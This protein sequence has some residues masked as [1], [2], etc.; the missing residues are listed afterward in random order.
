MSRHLPMIRSDPSLVAVNVCA[1]FTGSYFGWH[2][3][4]MNGVPFSVPTPDTSRHRLLMPVTIAGTGVGR[5]GDVPDPVRHGVD[6]GLDGAAPGLGLGVA[7]A[8]PGP[9]VDRDQLDPVSDLAERRTARVALADRRAALTRDVQPGRPDRVHRE[10]SGVQQV[11]DPLRARPPVAGDPQHVARGRRRRAEPHR[12]DVRDRVH[13]PCQHQVPVRPPDQLG[14]P[15]HATRRAGQIRAADGRGRGLLRYSPSARS[16]P[17]PRP[18]KQL[19]AVATHCRSTSAPVQRR[20]MSSIF[21]TNVYALAVAGVPP[22]MACAGTPPNVV[23]ASRPTAPAT[24]RRTAFIVPR[25]T[26]T[27]GTDARVDARRRCSDAG[28]A[29]GYGA[30]TPFGLPLLK[31]A[32]TSGKPARWPGNGTPGQRAAL[33]L[34]RSGS[35]HRAVLLLF[36]ASTLLQA[37][38][39]GRDVGLVRQ[40]LPVVELQVTAVVKVG[41]LTRGASRRRRRRQEW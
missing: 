7:A 8:L 15:H 18:G 11:R 5:I 16:L 6:A 4:R 31:S 28:R 41:L 21:V 9:V 12:R 1:S 30:R 13:Q 33:L 40:L 38:R 25:C 2:G 10:Q 29:A 20:S 32:T 24:R 19:A 22:P 35:G 27:S 3:R 26:R 37:A 23:M 34:E 14:H 17:A 36:P 39:A